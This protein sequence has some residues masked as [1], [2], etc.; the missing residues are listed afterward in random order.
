MGSA[1]TVTNRDIKQQIV[2]VVVKHHAPTNDRHTS[3]LPKDHRSPKKINKKV[4][5]S[6]CR[7]SLVFLRV[8]WLES[9]ILVKVPIVCHRLAKGIWI[10]MKTR[11]SNKEK[12][13]ELQ[14]GIWTYDRF[15]RG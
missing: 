14:R 15:D 12:T 2:G 9:H 4:N 11:K 5:F 7:V 8:F 10:G 3:R 6:L 13:E 1:T